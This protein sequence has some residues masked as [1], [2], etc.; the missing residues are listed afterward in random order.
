MSYTLFQSDF[1]TWWVRWS[2][3]GKR[4]QKSTGTK[5]KGQAQAIAAKIYEQAKTRAAG[6]EPLQTLEEVRGRWLAAN[7]ATASAGH[8]RNVNTWTDGGLGK[9]RVDRITSELVMLARTRLV[10][11]RGWADATANAWLRTLNLLGGFAVD[12]L[13]MVPEQPW[14]VPMLREKRRR[15]PTLPPDM[16]KAFL[17]AVD[18]AA[19]NPQVGTVVRLMVGL[20]VRESEALKARWDWFDEGQGLCT[21]GDTKGGEATPIPVPRWLLGHLA[22]LQR[23]IGL[24][25]PNK[26]GRPHPTGFTR[27]SMRA[28]CR[29]LG[30]QGVSAHRLRGTWITELLRAGTPPKD[31]QHM[32]RHK[33]LETT[34]LYYEES[35]D[36]RRE[37]QERLARRQGL[38]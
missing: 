37:A 18:A 21:P 27:A 25:A 17:E 35:E 8:W 30:V 32:A 26:D 16:T 12:V 19:R 1:G 9:A 36:A 2:I 4:Q 34:M 20:G 10:E 14:G 24:I 28:A 31:V 3:N 7:A 22:G 6:T 29:V 11:D 13:R 33:R 23:G 5:I 15:K 38:A